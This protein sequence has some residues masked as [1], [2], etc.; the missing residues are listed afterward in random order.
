[1][2]AGVVCGSE[3]VSRNPVAEDLGRRLEL[4]ADRKGSGPGKS[5]AGCQGGQ[6]VGCEEQLT[7]A[8]K[9]S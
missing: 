3:F 2:D 5:A 9:P 8:S 7:G 4:G 1:V 6:P